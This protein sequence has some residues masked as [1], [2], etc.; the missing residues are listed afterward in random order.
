MRLLVN[1]GLS[2]QEQKLQ[3]AYAD[4]LA[5]TVTLLLQTHGVAQQTAALQ[6]ELEQ[7]STDTQKEDVRKRVQQ[8][9]HAIEQQAKEELGL[10]LIGRVDLNHVPQAESLAAQLC[11]CPEFAP[12]RSLFQQAR[13]AGGM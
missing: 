13:Q 3:N 6:R 1:W 9:L 10:D 8:H 4:Q 11:A 7:A 2:D 5:H 12:A